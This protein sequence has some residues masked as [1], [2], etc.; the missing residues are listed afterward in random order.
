MICVWGSLNR[1]KREGF[2][3]PLLR[4]CEIPAR[5]S[6]CHRNNEETRFDFL[7]IKISNDFVEI[8]ESAKV[9]RV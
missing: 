8:V 3:A 6:T 1:A 4:R 9:V 2:S 7:S 5:P